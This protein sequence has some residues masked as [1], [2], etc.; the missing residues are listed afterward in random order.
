M[1]KQNKGIVF[2]FY[3]SV[4]WK[5]IWTYLTINATSRLPPA[6]CLISH[7]NA[8]FASIVGGCAKQRHENDAL[9]SA[10]FWLTHLQT[11]DTWQLAWAANVWQFYC[12]SFSY[13]FHSPN[14]IAAVLNWIQ[15]LEKKNNV[16]Y[17]EWEWC[18]WQQAN[19]RRRREK[20]WI[21][22][23]G[24]DRSITHRSSSR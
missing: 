14:S 17:R 6:F 7:S 2:E 19:A 12:F 5:R 20:K 4:Q 23:R 24:M 3:S 11:D 16:R 1:Q 9:Y 15:K 13:F 21:R 18:E 22:R 10:N 8:S